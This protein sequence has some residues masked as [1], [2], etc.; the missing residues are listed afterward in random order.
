MGMA[1]LSDEIIFVVL[2]DQW[3]GAGRIF[4]VLAF[5]AF[6]QPLL[7]TTGWIYI[8][9]GQTDRMMK[10]SLVTVPACIAVFFIGL[11]WGAYGVAVSYTLYYLFMVLPNFMYAIKESPIRLVDVLKSVWRPL[12]ISL[13]I[14]IASIYSKHIL[15]GFSQIYI[16]ALSVMISAI[17]FIV[18]ILAWPKAKNE[19][20]ELRDAIKL[21]WSRK[22][23]PIQA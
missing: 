8:S 10:W 16:L 21:I 9:L 7:N 11:P 12:T 3:S 2:G 13:F 18:S 5:A 1:A 17:V 4:K 14:Y 6:F 22:Y 23:S 20:S 15:N 19:T